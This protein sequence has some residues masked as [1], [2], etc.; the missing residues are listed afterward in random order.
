MAAK[1]PVRSVR[2]SIQCQSR[3]ALPSGLLIR[4][5]RI[6]R[7]VLCLVVRV[8]G[9]YRMSN[10]LSSKVQKKPS[11]GEELTGLACMKITRTSLQDLVRYAIEMKR[12]ASQV[13]VCR[14]Q[15]IRRSL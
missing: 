13:R 6:C 10:T 15:E 8:C 4:C 1:V 3:P 11:R 5:K 12:T 7:L 14:G 9:C 2:W